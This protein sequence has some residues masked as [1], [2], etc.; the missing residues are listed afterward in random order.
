MRVYDGGGGS[1]VRSYV[2]EPL[3]G[4]LVGVGARLRTSC[5]GGLGVLERRRKEGKR[6]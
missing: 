2:E 4:L 6:G 5:F 1:G 3:T